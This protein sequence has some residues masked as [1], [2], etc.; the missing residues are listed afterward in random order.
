MSKAEARSSQEYANSPSNQSSEVPVIEVVF[1]PPD[2]ERDGRIMRKVYALIL[3]G[4]K[5]TG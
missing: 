5:R 4:A 1:A 3:G 2:P